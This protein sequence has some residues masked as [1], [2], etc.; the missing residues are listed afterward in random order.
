MRER[1]IERK[2]EREKETGS[3]RKKQGKR[4][5]VKGESERRRDVVGPQVRALIGSSDCSLVADSIRGRSQR[6]CLSFLD[7]PLR[8]SAA[9]L[10]EPLPLR[11]PLC[12]TRFYV[13]KPVNRS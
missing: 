9:G 2:E 1:L 3:K 8:D 5:G 4:A 12:S 11:R 6:T 10:Y 13:A 7:L